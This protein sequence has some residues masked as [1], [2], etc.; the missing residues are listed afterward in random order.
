MSLKSPLGMPGLGSA[1]QAHLLL[2]WQLLLLHPTAAVDLS[3][4]A[5]VGAGK[6]DMPGQDVRRS[7]YCDILEYACQV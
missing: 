3:G 7:H 6:P 4:L 1:S 2:H 5:W